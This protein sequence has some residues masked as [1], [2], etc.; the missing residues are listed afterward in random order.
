MTRSIVLEGREIKYELLRKKVKR[1]NLHVKSDGSVWVS[2]SNRVTVAEIERF[3]VKNADFFLRALDKFAARGVSEPPQYETGDAVRLLGKDY[4]LTVCEG[5]KNS[6]CVLE[7]RILL[8]VKDADDYEM[9]RKCLDDWLK[10]QCRKVID[11]SC[12]RLYPA[13][14]KRGVKPPKEIRIRT[15]KSKWGS[16]MP[17]KGVLTFNTN[18][19]AAPQECVDY[20]VA[21]E[22]NHFL[23][24]D[25][26]PAF[27][28]SLA[29]VI[30][31]WKRLR[32]ET[33]EHPVIRKR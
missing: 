33:N 1:I 25:H 30:P 28:A 7:G 19:I 12:G 17:Q 22:F 5:G 4:E 13:F 11:E 6:V 9:K 23:H 31:D 3:M 27:Y 2:A 14:E 15:M 21:H 10:M 29:E 20:V 32:K 26:S 24:P 8:T 18:L 16:C